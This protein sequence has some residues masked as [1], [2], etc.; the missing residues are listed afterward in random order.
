MFPFVC[1]RATLKNITSNYFL[2][3]IFLCMNTVDLRISRTYMLVTWQTVLLLNEQS[4]VTLLR[5][6]VVNVTLKSPG[7]VQELWLRVQ[8]VLF[9]LVDIAWRARTVSK[10]YFRNMFLNIII[11]LK[12][13]FR[14]ICI[15]AAENLISIA[16]QLNIPINLCGYLMKS[17]ELRH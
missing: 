3:N 15:T 14:I 13:T 1:P 5:I 8:Y 7:L 6:L 11:R 10:R 9:S 12:K 4:Q 2:Y 16:P 17:A